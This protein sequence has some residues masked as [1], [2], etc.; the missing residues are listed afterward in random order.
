M[1]A[2]ETDYRDVLDLEREVEQ[3]RSAI[4]EAIRCQLLSVDF[5]PTGADGHRM[6]GVKATLKSGD[7]SKQWRAGNYLLIPVDFNYEPL[8]SPK[9]TTP[10]T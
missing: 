2:P 10:E 9:A 4:D 3:L 5:D 6:Y 7:S 8:S 1:T